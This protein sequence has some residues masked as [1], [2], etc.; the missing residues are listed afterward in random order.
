VTNLRAGGAAQSRRPHQPGDAL[1]SDADP[2]VISRLCVDHRRAAGL[3][4]A[5]MNL[6]NASAER[7]IGSLPS[8]YRTLLPSIEAAR[9][10][11]KQPPHDL[12][13]VGGRVRLHESEERFGI[14]GFSAAN[15]ASAFD[16]TLQNARSMH[17]RVPANYSLTL[18]SA[19][20]HPGCSR[21]TRPERFGSVSRNGA[22]RAA[23]NV[24]SGACIAK[25]WAYMH[26][27][28]P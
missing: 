5:T 23:K 17:F 28:N 7:D 6:V 10:H 21:A 25:E 3:A 11:F 27:S 24:S 19:S 22:D 4:R 13:R 20:W 2:I 14:A 8:R 26:T 16:I 15:Q 9:G 18:P 1:A 12:Y